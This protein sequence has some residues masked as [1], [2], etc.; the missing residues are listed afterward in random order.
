MQDGDKSSVQ[1]M[2]S[3]HLAACTSVERLVATRYIF[4]M[5]YADS[6]IFLR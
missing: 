4:L 1:L 3:L 6:M 5:V 2:R